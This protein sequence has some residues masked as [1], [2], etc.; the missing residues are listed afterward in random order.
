MTIMSPV[1]K[2]IP[3]NAKKNFSKR[4]LNLRKST[5]IPTSISNV[6]K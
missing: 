1:I 5:Q 3:P 2:N 4:S 6:K